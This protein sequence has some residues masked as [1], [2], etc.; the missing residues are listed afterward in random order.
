MKNAPPA[1]AKEVKI[2]TLDPLIEGLSGIFGEMQT[3]EIFP[4]YLIDWIY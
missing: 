2:E 4:W 1:S 3:S